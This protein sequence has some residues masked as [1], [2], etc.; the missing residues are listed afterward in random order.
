M[1]GYNTLTERLQIRF[2][3]IQAG[4]AGGATTP[5]LVAAVSNAGGLG[6]LG[7]GYMSP[8]HMKEAIRKIKLLTDKPFAVNLFVPEAQV[9]VPCVQEPIQT[10]LASIRKRLHMAGGQEAGASEAVFDYDAYQRS[11][12]EQLSVVIQ[13]KVPVFSFT[14]GVPSPEIMHQ[15]KSNGIVVIGTATHVKE[16]QILVAAGVDLVVAQGSEAGGHRGTFHGACEDSLV[17]TIALVPLIADHVSVPVIAAGGI[18]DGRGMAAAMALGAQGVQLGT[19]FLACEESGAHEAYKAAVLS[20]NERSTIVTRTFSGKLARGIVN[21]F[22]RQLQPYAEHVPPY[23][24]M[25]QLTRDIRQEAARQSNPEYLSLWAGQAARL[26]R[27]T[28]AHDVVE[29][30]IHRWQEVVHQMK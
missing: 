5:D 16:A 25:N 19:A 26:G 7:A 6:T 3:V 9:D 21:D 12:E 8:Q 13:E 22:I 18:M 29:K 30:L 10:Q 2:P 28:T 23:P 17:G 14:F 11:F 15:L 27:R 1:N 24:I 20:S 4:M